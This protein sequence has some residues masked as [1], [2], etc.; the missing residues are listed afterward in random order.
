MNVRRIL[1]LTFA[2]GLAA[3]GGPADPLAVD[4]EA[5]SDTDRDL[6]RVAIPDA[7]PEGI[8]RTIELDLAGE[9]V[10]G[11]RVV[12]LIEHSYRGDLKVTLRSPSGTAVVLHDQEG[13]NARDLRVDATMYAEFAGELASGEWALE[14]ADLAAWDT[15]TLVG[16]A[17]VV[18][19]EPAPDLCAAVRCGTNE[20]CMLEQVECVR[21]PCPP[22]AVCVN[23]CAAALC[24]V[25]TICEVQQV[26]C[27]RAPCPPLAACVPAPAACEASECGPP[28]PV[29]PLTCEDGSIG[30][31]VSCERD[32]GGVCRWNVVNECP[33]P[34][35]GPFCG[36]RGREVYC[37]VGEYCHHE[38]AEICGWADALGECRARPELCTEQ[39]Q[40]VCGCDDQTYGNACSANM[41]GVS[42]QHTGECQA[43][44]QRQ[45][46]QV[47]TGSP[48]ENDQRDV[49]TFDPPVRSERV[50]IHFARF[51][52][53][54]NYD[55]III[56]DAN[57][58]V[59]TRYHGALG[60]FETE[61]DVPGGTFSVVFE[62]D[63]SITRDGVAI[64]ALEWAY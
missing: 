38:P 58:D 24:P 17:I 11:L 2:A 54:R 45:A 47:D 33:E 29:A 43:R 42:V 60:A 12:A 62:S 30:T 22:V 21:A 46:V 61:I 26:E 49:W 28:P 25:G 63:Y 37:A 39:Y 5:L 50:K 48:Y 35:Q 13:A 36:S 52:T 9:V 4:L 44:W 7:D 8:R 23:P 55:F 14:V 18:Q 27:V 6:T 15:G 1:P 20:V 51:D 3:C 16:W 40:P 56:E 31:Q 19:S 34:Q 57:G 53:E 32:L 64:D 41:A 10:V 59:I